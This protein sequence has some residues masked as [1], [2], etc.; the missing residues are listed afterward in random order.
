MVVADTDAEETSID[1][2]AIP[3]KAKDDT[4]VPPLEGPTTS[5]A[6]NSAIDD[7][8]FASNSNLRGTLFVMFN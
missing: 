4:P 5:L 7:G 1:D 2:K 6:L 3:N 8:V